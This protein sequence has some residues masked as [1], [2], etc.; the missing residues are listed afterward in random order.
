M[1][2]YVKR[3]VKKSPLLYAFIGITIFFKLITIVPF[4]YNIS[5]GHS[6]GVFETSKFY[7]ELRSISV[8]HLSDILSFSNLP[9]MEVRGVFER[10]KL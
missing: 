2:D 10:G 5:V 3:K 9:K 1:F 4:A 7:I 6:S 8:A